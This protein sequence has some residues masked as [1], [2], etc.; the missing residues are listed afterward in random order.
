MN[1]RYNPNDFISFRA[2]YSSGFRAP[3]IYDE[4]LHGNEIGGNDVIIKLNPNLKPETSQSYS[5][6]IDFN[7]IFGN[8][9]TDLLIEGFYTVLNNVFV[10][11]EIGIQ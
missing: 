2:S 11:N 7:K 1:L 6:S 10:L 5:G 3:Q 9:Q 4:D 8:V